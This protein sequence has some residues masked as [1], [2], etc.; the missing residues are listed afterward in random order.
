MV[1]S[2]TARSSASARAVVTP[3][4]RSRWTIRKRRSAR[5]TDAAIL[6]LAGWEDA[7]LRA[8]RIAQ[9]AEDA[10]RD[11]DALAHD[12]RTE[13][14]SPL[15]APCAIVDADVGEPPGDAFEHLVGEPARRS[16]AGVDHRVLASRDGDGSELPI[17]E[18]RVESAGALH[19]LRVKLRIGERIGHGSSLPRRRPGRP[20]A[21][22]GFREGRCT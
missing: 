16:F 14:S 13:V 2:D 20:Q 9:D 7:D 10:V 8:G 17:E 6:R 15:R 4:R 5:R 3:R 12:L 19:V 18:L 1:R 22:A 11:L 21:L